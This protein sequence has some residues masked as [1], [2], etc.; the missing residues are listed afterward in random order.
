MGVTVGVTVFVGVTLGAGGVAVTLG[1]AVFVGVTLGVAVFVGV[2][3]GV[4]VTLGVTLG[5]GVTLGTE[6]NATSVIALVASTRYEVH[7]K[8]N[9]VDLRSVRSTVLCNTPSL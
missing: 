6:T 2:K 8:Y 1:V 9:G 5:V 3:L 7:M 4:A